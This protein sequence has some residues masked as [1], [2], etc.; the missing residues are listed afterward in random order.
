LKYQPT[1]VEEATKTSYLIDQMFI[2]GVKQNRDENDSNHD[3][4]Y[5]DT[6]EVEGL[7]Y[8]LHKYF[9]GFHPYYIVVKNEE[10]FNKM[11]KSDVPVEK[12]PQ[13]EVMQ[14][15][16]KFRDIT[17]KM[18]KDMLERSH[19]MVLRSTFLIRDF[20]K[21]ESISGPESL[22]DPAYTGN[23]IVIFECQLK[24]PSSMALIDTSLADFFN[25]NKISMSN[26]R[27]ADVDHF[28]RGNSFFN[29]L[30]AETDWHSAVEKVVGTKDKLDF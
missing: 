20:C 2:K 5:V 17:F 15:Q 9:L 3:Y 14:M 11:K 24:A 26:W 19:S 1:S 12:L 28:M 22:F 16:D 29:R 21:L 10:F 25:L 30:V 6:N 4:M 23:H 8:Y 18:R 13:Q 7:R 27:I